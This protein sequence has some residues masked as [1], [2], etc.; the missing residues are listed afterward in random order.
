MSF[1]VTGERNG[2]KDNWRLP[3]RRERR[4]ALPTS[5]G[6]PLAYLVDA[7]RPSYSARR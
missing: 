4:A 5:R 6:E 1:R 2:D 3:A 7:K